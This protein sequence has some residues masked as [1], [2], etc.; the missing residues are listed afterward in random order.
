MNENDVVPGNLGYLDH[1][2]VISD[3]QLSNKLLILISSGAVGMRKR[4]KKKQSQIKM[5]YDDLQSDT[6][7]KNETGLVAWVV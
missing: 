3:C 4:F 2:N 7:R 1:N 5:S 6:K